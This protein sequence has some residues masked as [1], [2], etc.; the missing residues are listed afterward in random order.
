MKNPK[1]RDVL[2][3]PLKCKH[4]EYHESSLGNCKI[5]KKIGGYFCDSDIDT[6]IDEDQFLLNCPYASRLHVIK[7]LVE[8]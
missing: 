7:D 2:C 1:L 3:L 5:C 6:Y 4:Y 8:L